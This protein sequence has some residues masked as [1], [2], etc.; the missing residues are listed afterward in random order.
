[1]FV[2]VCQRKKGNAGRPL[3]GIHL[4]REGRLSTLHLRK[5]TVGVQRA[6]LK[7]LVWAQERQIGRNLTKQSLDFCIY[8]FVQ[9][10]VFNDNESLLFGRKEAFPF[11][12]CTLC[13]R[14]KAWL[15]S[16]SNF[17]GVLPVNAPTFASVKLY[18]PSKL[19]FSFSRRWKTWLELR[20]TRSPEKIF[21]F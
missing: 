3:R 20:T 9:F 5:A 4:Q 6:S 12:L 16:R 19:R 13:S 14:G 1:M 11:C 8:R 15:L 21:R 10:F 17:T 7:V 18:L 2:F